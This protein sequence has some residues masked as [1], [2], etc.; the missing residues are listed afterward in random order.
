MAEKRS[1]FLTSAPAFLSPKFGSGKHI[2]LPHP[3]AA[4][5]GIFAGRKMLNK[6]V[7]KI[8]CGKGGK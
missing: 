7:K 8:L 5:D 2:R 1:G 3:Q 6:M 4:P